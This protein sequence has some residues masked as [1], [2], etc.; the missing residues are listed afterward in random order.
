MYHKIISFD[1]CRID[2]QGYLRSKR[3]YGGCVEFSPSEIPSNE[4][5][6][7]R[8][9][10]IA[11]FDVKFDTKEP[12]ELKSVYYYEDYKHPEY[13]PS[14]YKKLTDEELKEHAKEFM[15]KTGIQSFDEF[16]K[17]I[18]DLWKPSCYV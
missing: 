4:L 7:C 17:L 11:V 6:E 8:W 12:F 18:K 16:K 3:I 15:E 5:I 13:D 2:V 9:C 1:L 14:K 10:Y